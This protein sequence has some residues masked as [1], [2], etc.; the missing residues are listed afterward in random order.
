MGNALKKYFDGV[1]SFNSFLELDNENQNIEIE[2]GRG[3]EEKVQL[4]YSFNEVK[5]LLV[6]L[7]EELR[8]K[9]SK[10]LN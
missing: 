3:I 1:N 6:Q 7:M 4:I 8:E 10:I 2:K 5:V 9:H